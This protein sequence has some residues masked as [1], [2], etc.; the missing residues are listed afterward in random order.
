MRGTKASAEDVAVLVFELA[1]AVRARAD[2][3]AR[4]R[5]AVTWHAFAATHGDLALEVRDG[6]L[7]LE[8]GAPVAGPGAAEVAGLFEAR[9]LRVLR[10]TGE[11][12]ETELATLLE[13]LARE[14]EQIAES[15]GF[16][17]ALRASGARAFEAFSREGRTTAP[18]GEDAYFA[19]QIAE[20]VRL[21]A[22]LE[23]CDE[24]AS[25]NLI[26][27]KIEICAE[28]LV[29]AKRGMDAYRAVLV[30]TR[31]STDEARPQPIRREA[32]D[33][34]RRLTQHDELLGA[35]IE[36]ACGSS[37]LASVQANQVLICL[38]AA[39]VPALLRQLEKSK[40]PMRARVT[41]ALIAV[42]DSAATLAAEELV[43]GTPERAK[44]AARLLGEMQN[45]RGVPFLTEALAGRDAAVAREA[46]QALARIGGDAAV[47]AL[48][49]GLERAPEIAETC[50]SNLGGLRHPLAARV[51]GDLVDPASRRP[52][53][54]RRAAIRSLGRLGGPEALARLKR[55]LDHNPTFGRARVRALRVAAAQ[56]IAQIGGPAAFQ[57]LYAHARGGDAAVRQ[58]CLEALRRLER[59]VSNE[60][61]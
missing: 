1:R 60:R 37:G 46:A 41:Q 39:A 18:G 50:A 6:A 33:R 29:R 23:R 38:G 34:L 10:A 4:R 45:P 47:Q 54:L 52:E 5:L 22:E 25:Y 40:D 17:Q 11:P 61:A 32:S 53:N 51:L 2:A 55:V 8:R 27:N 43:S 21:L 42:G 13:L 24:V 48:V 44:R 28:V 35:V 7:A 3:S 12:P 36:Q 15:G 57:A 58:A 31:H 30:L 16:A 56:A 59:A 19:G 14:P 49:A 9:H 20:L 26:T